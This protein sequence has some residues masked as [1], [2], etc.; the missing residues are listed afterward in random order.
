M[1]GS[2][3]HPRITFKQCSLIKRILQVIVPFAQENSP[4]GGLGLPPGLF[5]LIKRLSGFSTPS[6][7][8][9]WERIKQSVAIADTFAFVF[10][11]PPRPR[12]TRGAR[13]IA[14]SLAAGS[15]HGGVCWGVRN[16]RRRRT[17][18]KRYSLYTCWLS[19][20]LLV[21]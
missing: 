15:Q 1:F 20:R 2:F 21:V 16:S 3:Y 12:C 19:R 7:S 4:T 18:L 14:I 13:E 8:I 5:K 9:F 11:P 10:C 17:S 6:V